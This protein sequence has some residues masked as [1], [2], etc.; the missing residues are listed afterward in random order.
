M[1]VAD[2]AARRPRRTRRRR[3]AREI[4]VPRPGRAADARAS[5]ESSPGASAPSL[6]TH[7]VRDRPGASCSPR[8]ALERLGE[9]RQRRLVDRQSG[10]ERM[11]AER[12]GSAPGSRLLT[13][14]SASRRWKPAI[15]RPE[16]L[17]SPSL[18]RAKTIA[19]RWK[20]SLSRDATM[21][22]TPWCHVGPKQAQR[23]ARRP[24]RA[25][26]TP[27]IGERLVLHRRLDVAALAIEP[28]EL[29]RERQRASSASSASRQR[30]PIDMSAR[31][32]A[33][34]S[35][36]PAT[37]P[38]SVAVASRDV[39]A[40]D[41]EQR[42]HAGAAP[43]AR[44]CAASPARRGCGSRGRGGRRRR[45]CRARRGRAATR[46][47]AGRRRSRRVAQ[48]RARRGEH[49]EHHADAGE[50]LRRERARRAGWD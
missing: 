34:F 5:S 18:P 29:G 27:A 25:T 2:D 7:A 43:C 10:G 4:P 49:V 6:S 33:A 19:A 45:R 50:M 12:G 36:G 41:V 11:A 40:R 24:R 20:R 15:E 37:K 13:R 35:R 47:S 42:E 1:R 39:A 23:V 38:R 14:S 26:A 8:D 46:G 30:M 21:P 17:S 16:P 32:P 22:T 48:L 44:A 3:P 9:A 31:R 28:I